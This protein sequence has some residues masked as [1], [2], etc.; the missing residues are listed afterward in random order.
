MPQ[1]TKSQWLEMINRTRPTEF[2]VKALE[3]EFARHLESD[4]L[5]ESDVQE[6]R[7]ALEQR[8]FEPVGALLGAPSPT[9]HPNASVEYRPNG[10]GG[11]GRLFIEIEDRVQLEPLEN[12]ALDELKVYIMT[13][14]SRFAGVQVDNATELPPRL[15][16]AL[17]A[18]NALE[19]PV[20]DCVEADL[21]GARISDVLVWA[22]QN[23]VLAGR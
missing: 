21:E 1:R 2:A 11:K 9:Q 20:V 10:S 8:S 6:I 18:L 19:L 13:D 23:R 12:P 14:G 16:D 15:E 3:T 5:S 17:D 7:A 22:V 4:G